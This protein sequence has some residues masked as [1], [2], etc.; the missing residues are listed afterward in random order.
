MWMKGRRG[1][2]V[3]PLDHA[4]GNNGGAVAPLSEPSVSS[5]RSG[6][7]PALI[8]VYDSLTATPRVERVSGTDARDLIETLATRTYQLSHEAGGA[9][10]YSVI[11][12]VVENFIHASFYEII[13][14]ILDGGT[15]IR[16]SDQGPG[17]HDKERAFQPGFSTAT[18]P[19]KTVIK[20]VGSGLPVARECMTF[21]NGTIEID[22]NLGQGTVVTI[23]MS[24]PPPPEIAMGPTHDDL[25]LPALTLRQKQVLS[26]ALELG[27]V[28][29]TV[30][31]RELGVGLSTAFRDL[32]YLG[33]CGLISSDDAGKRILTEIGI[34]SL[35][36]LFGR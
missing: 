32:E 2:L 24:S 20:G 29:P 4:Y 35:D 13:V 31:S 23:R 7:E 9:V 16:F 12:E 10:P 28:G 27:S 11:R 30:V 18:T 25:V 15:V 14:S 17:I 34:Q 5:E 22:D 19:M 33:Q 6:L 21:S 3:E 26:L 1:V 8:A 36:A